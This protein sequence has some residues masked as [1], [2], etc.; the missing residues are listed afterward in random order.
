MR[1]NNSKYFIFTP[2][3]VLNN[4]QVL[5][6]LT[7]HQFYHYLHF[8]DEKIKATTAKVTP[9]ALTAQPGFNP[10]SLAPKR[11]ITTLPRTA[12]DA[13]VWSLWNLLHFKN[14]ILLLAF[15]Q[16]SKMYWFAESLSF[17][18]VKIINF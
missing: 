18:S 15:K 6:H 14:F 3:P 9:K 11:I 1:V 12:M 5:T 7:L 17:K 13:T 8:N 4:V 10:R 2:G 16:Y